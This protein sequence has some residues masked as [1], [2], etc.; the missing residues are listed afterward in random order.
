M[1]N[2]F[3]LLCLL[4]FALP[5]AAWDFSGNNQATIW[6]S[7]GDSLSGGAYNILQY[8]EACDLRLAGRVKDGIRLEAGL[9]FLYD[10][11]TWDDQPLFS[12]F[13]KRYLQLKTDMLT[14]RIGTYYVALGRGLVLNCANEQ[15]AKIDRQLDG[16]MA[17]ASVDG[18]G[19][20]RLLFGRISENTREL[21]T[22]MTYLGIELKFTKLASITPGLAYL[23]ANAAGQG[24]DPSL[25]KPVE[26]TYSGSLAGNLGPVEYYG[27]YG[28]RRTYGRL[29]PTAGW[30]GIKDINGHAIYGSLSASSS[31]LGVMMDFKDYR[32][33]DAG[34]NAPPPCNREGRLLNNGRGERGFQLDITTTPWELLELHGNIS[35]AKSTKKSDNVSV[36]DGTVY[37]GEQKWGDILAECRWE[38]SSSIIFTGEARS[39]REDNLQPDIIV[40]KYQGASAGIVWRYSADQTLSLK[41]G[42]NRYHNIYQTENLDYDEV[43]AELGWVPLK[44]LNV[45][46]SAD[47]ADKPVAEYDGQKS[48]GET[49]CS[50]DLDQGRQQLKLSVGKT[51][52]GLVCSGGF[53]R[54]EPAFRGFKAVWSWKF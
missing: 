2:G 21:D 38:Y 20:A 3:I 48:W 5:A 8:R 19:D 24:S 50:V 40:K 49:G 37:P 28:G 54:W 26:E 43:L 46:A 35:S 47:L 25:G 34:I 9:K 32:D 39:R 10:Q 12:G 29:S 1:R 7:R 17:S 33:F 41:A 11:E 53:C 23:R 15:A 16:A 22:S 27:E 51:K 52:G 6:V 31:G 42:G 4:A 44:W 36:S 18:L 14:A 45:F 30:V 13:S